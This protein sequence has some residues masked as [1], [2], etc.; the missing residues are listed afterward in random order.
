[1]L[2]RSEIQGE[3]R[4]ASKLL[5]RSNGTGGGGIKRLDR[6]LLPLQLALAPPALLT[7][8]LPEPAA[9]MLLPLPLLPPPLLPLTPPP[10]SPLLLHP[11]LLLLLVAAVLAGARQPGKLPALA[12]CA[13][14]AQ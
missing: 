4:E 12:P 10:P 9:P 1:M 2:G 14:D 8:A 11:P 13:G 7:G 5:T 6:R 3:R